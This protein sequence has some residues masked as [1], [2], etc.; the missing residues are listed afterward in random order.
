M[1][2]FKERSTRDY[3]QKKLYT[4]EELFKRENRCIYEEPAFCHAACPLGLDAK[5]LAFFIEKGAFSDARAMLEHITPFPM[6]LAYGCDAP[7]EKASRMNEVV[8][9][10]NIRVLERAAK[11]HGS[12]KGGKG[13]FKFKKTKGRVLVLIYFHF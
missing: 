4:M 12:P 2:H 8:E 5:K 1:D 6:I 13:L 10:I 11:Y 3:F 7:C 9:G